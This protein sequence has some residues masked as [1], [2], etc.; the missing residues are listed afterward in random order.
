MEYDIYSAIKRVA[1]EYGLSIGDLSER[2]G[3][4][5]ASL[6]VTMQRPSY[7]SLTKLAQ[8]I[9][10]SP[11]AFFPPH[12]PKNTDGNDGQSGKA[13]D[14]NADT[15]TAT[16][17]SPTPVFTPPVVNTGGLERNIRSLT[18]AVDALTAAIRNVTIS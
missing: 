11:A 17:A 3:V 4:S 5:R 7:P 1:A 10:V 2:M 18:S 8:I 13:E 6:Y 15:N 14:N 9:G 12:I 16:T